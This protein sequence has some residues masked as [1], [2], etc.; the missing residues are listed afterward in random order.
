[1]EQERI[2]AL[3]EEAARLDM[4]LHEE[5]TEPVD[6]VEVAPVQPD[7]YRTASVTMGTAKRWHFEVGDFD[8]LPREYK[9][10][11]TTKIRR[12]VTAG[13]SIPGVRSW[14]EDELRVKA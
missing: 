14:Q 13:A 8:A 3:R 4:K 10:P 5:V 1:M 7:H 12:V 9:R 2:N 6:L 11:D